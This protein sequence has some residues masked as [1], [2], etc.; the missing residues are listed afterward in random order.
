MIADFFLRLLLIRQ[1]Y[2]CV[3]DV[4]TVFVYHF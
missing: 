1:R 3:G 2:L 4:A